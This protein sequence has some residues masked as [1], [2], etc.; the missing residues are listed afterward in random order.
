MD[1]T[2]QQLLAGKYIIG[3]DPAKD[4][5]QAIILDPDSLQLGKSFCFDVSYEGYTNI[6][7]KKITFLFPRCNPENTIFAIETSCNLWTTLAFYL[8][9]E[10]YTVVMVSPLTTHL[11]RPMAHHDFSRTD[12]K[13]ALLVASNAQQGNCDLYQ[14]YSASSNAMHRLGITYDKLR[15]ELAQNRSRLRSAIEQI[16]PEFLSI[17]EPDTQTA[18]YLLKRYLF[19][20]DF[21]DL[22]RE[23]E[24]KAITTISRHQYGLNTLLQLHLAAQR[25]ICIR[26]TLEE[27]PAER[28]TVNS[29][30]VIIETLEAQIETIFSALVSLAQ[31]LPE[32]DILRSLKGV[33][34]LSSALFLAE[35]RDIHRFSHYKQI[36][37][38]AGFNLRLSQSGRYV[39]SRHISHLGNKRLQWLLYCMAEETAKWV[40]EVRIKLLR[41][42]LKFSKYRKNI[43]AS[44]TPLLKLI[45]ILVKEQRPYQYKDETLAQMRILEQQVTQR[46]EERQKQRKHAA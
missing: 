11:S 21:L 20:E 17:L 15:K 26:K 5:H 28:L 24:A 41:R 13:D 29:W 27:C 32:Y 30:L 23:L 16:F 1:L 40:P 35:V 39:G 18:R 10:G 42:Q 38:Y 7:W 36:Q 8:R 6:L 25:S 43:V 3:I 4:K 19:P 45:M 9:K 46:K 22:D 33:S 2:K 37:K 44:T 12:P 34:H 31:Q 14:E